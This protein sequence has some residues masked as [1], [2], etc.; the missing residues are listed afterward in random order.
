MIIE[1]GIDKDGITCW[2]VLDGPDLV[3]MYYT[4]EEAQNVV[5]NG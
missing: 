4:L 5:N 3:G 1:Q 2:F